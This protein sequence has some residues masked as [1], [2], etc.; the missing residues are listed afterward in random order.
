[1]SFGTPRTYCLQPGDHGYLDAVAESTERPDLAIAQVLHD[2]GA[3]RYEVVVDGTRRG[4]AE[5]E[6][7][8]D[9][10]TFTHTFTDPAMRGRGLAAIVVRR[11]LDDSRIAGRTVV[12][13]CW[14]V[15]QFIDQRPE[16]AD[17]LALPG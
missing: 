4:Y 12:P 8:G 3:S 1:M 10:I 11:A 14:Y 15:A 7:H 2:Q 17:L 13:Q 9:Q 16:Y 5:Y 6:L